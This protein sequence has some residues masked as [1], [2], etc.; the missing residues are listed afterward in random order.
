[1]FDYNI[2]IKLLICLIPLLILWGISYLLKTKKLGKQFLI[3]N[4]N[5]FTKVIE[6]IHLS[7]N[8]SLYLIQIGE[9][10]IILLSV[11][12]TGSQILK[13]YQSTDLKPMIETKN[14]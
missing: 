12:P 8:N 11:S 9:N 6:E 3:G 10:E 7:Q 5:N 4:K 13:N 1:M 14:N 2:L